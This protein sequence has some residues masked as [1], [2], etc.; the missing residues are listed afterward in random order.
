MNFSDMP[1]THWA[2]SYVSY[3]Y[4][5]G[6]IGGYAD[7]TFRPDSGSTRG[8]FTKMLV[9]GLDWQPYAPALPTFSD[10]PLGSTFYP[11]V[12]A[13]VEHGVINGY[14]DGT[15]R[16]GNPL[17]RAQT[18]KILVLGR[19]W[20]LVIPPSPTFPDV[21]G[22]HWAYA[23]VETAFSH[24]IIGGFPDGTFG[25]ERP[26]NRAQLAKMVALAAQAP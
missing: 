21:L 12:E 3:L 22:D 13:A 14:S 7:G 11:Y 25:P 20:Q 4:C 5:A 10:V 1:D 9:L 16:P 26:V 17:T 18:A 2:Y 8:Q 23:Y 15:F 24:G 19:Q 6:A